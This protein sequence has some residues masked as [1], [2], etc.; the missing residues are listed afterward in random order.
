M[1]FFKNH[2]FYVCLSLFPCLLGPDGEHQD[3]NDQIM[4]R[5]APSPEGAPIGILGGTPEKH[6][7]FW[8]A[9]PYLQRQKQPK[10]HNTF[11]LTH[12]NVH[13]RGIA[14]GGVTV[15][16]GPEARRGFALKHGCSGKRET[17]VAMQRVW[18]PKINL[19]IVHC[20]RR[21]YNRQPFFNF[22]HSL[23]KQSHNESSQAMQANM[24]RNPLKSA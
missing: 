17:K 18:Q 13:P 5:F 19:E 3:I 10:Q 6:Y 21:S 2:V 9:L 22:S 23:H 20:K 8:G 16:I 11:G 4:A 7:F 24:C 14:A 15:F 12:Q 1:A